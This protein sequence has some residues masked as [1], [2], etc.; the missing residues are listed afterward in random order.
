MEIKQRKILRWSLF[1]FWIALIFIM[2]QQSGDISSEQSA[3]V[4]KVFSAIGIDLNGYFGEMATFVVRKVAHFTE[5]LIL[6]ILT[7]R[8]LTLY[9]GRKASKLYA[10][11]FVFLYACSDEFHQSFVAGR[12]PTFRDVLIDTA[13]GV[14]SCLVVSIREKIKNNS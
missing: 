7:Y 1:I 10:I 5:Y 8:V 4:V 3:I 2:S 9:M 11:M 12:G 14:F 13:G 6:F